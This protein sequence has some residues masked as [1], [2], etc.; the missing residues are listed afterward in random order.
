MMVFRSS[1]KFATQYFTNVFHTVFVVL[2]S[3]NFADE[4]WIPLSTTWRSFLLSFLMISNICLSLKHGSDALNETSKRCGAIW[5]YWRGSFYLVASY[6]IAFV[7]IFAS[8]GPAFR[9]KL[10][11]FFTE[12]WKSAYVTEDAAS[13]R[14]IF[15]LH[16]V[17]L[18]VRRRFCYF[19]KEEVHSDHQH[20]PHLQHY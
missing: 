4:N 3:S 15:H 5:S 6:K 10:H 18:C 16:S 20:R 14:R 11:M 9:I 8:F 13:E 2:S 19:P 17:I 7:H 1:V 12:R